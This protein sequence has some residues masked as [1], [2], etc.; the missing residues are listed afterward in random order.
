MKKSFIVFLMWILFSPTSLTAATV[1]ETLSFIDHLIP[2]GQ[3]NFRQHGVEYGSRRPCAIHIFSKRVS[4]DLTKAYISLGFIRNGRP[5][6]AEFTVQVNSAS[7]ELLASTIRT[8]QMMA[9]VMIPPQQP[10]D[11]KKRQSLNI[12]NTDQELYV[13]ITNEIRPFYFYKTKG[14]AACSFRK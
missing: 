9:S 8:G 13:S 4:G 5:A 10:R 7:N 11:P 1:Q 14:Q 3:K 12:E 6:I 2:Q